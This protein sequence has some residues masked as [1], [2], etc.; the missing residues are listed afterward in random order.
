MDKT[1]MTA[2]GRNWLTLACDPFHDLEVSTSGY[3]DGRVSHSYILVQKESIDLATPSVADAWDCHVSIVP[4]MFYYK[5]TGFPLGVD[6]HGIALYNQAENDFDLGNIVIHT[7]KAG[8][9]T[10]NNADEKF[11]NT[12]T[13]YALPTSNA[14]LEEG[15]ARVVAIGFEVHNTSAP[16]YRGG[17]VC[18]YRMPSGLSREMHY[19]S[20]INGVPVVY[21]HDQ[22]IESYQ[23]P[24]T[25]NL[26]NR[27]PNSKT[28]EAKDGAYVTGTFGVDGNDLQPPQFGRRIFVGHADNVSPGTIYM[29]SSIVNR[30]TFAPTAL[31]L[32]GAYFTNIPKE[33]TLRVN[34]V[35][36]LEVSPIPSSTT[37]SAAT[38]AAQYD[39]LALSSYFK[40]KNYF[41]CGVPVGYNAGGDWW[42]MATNIF[43]SVADK[44]PG[45]VDSTVFGGAP[46]ASSV[47]GL[48]KRLFKKGSSGQV[49]A[50]SK[51]NAKS[52]GGKNKNKS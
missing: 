43:R 52:G 18:C 35:R 30:L 21:G 39:D 49:N 17:S 20:D 25:L 2:D 8:E 12:A 4:E 48:G 28:W 9:P 22:F 47:V 27:I 34:I 15:A 23:P 36:Y 45:L 5:A 46:I 41:P 16:L 13:S 24:P 11:V 3:P 37:I 19:F 14:G 31:D 38:R 40:M 51:T 32:A 42:K 10:W 26:A 44:I 50:Q 7:V 6:D 29:A 1:N 33:G